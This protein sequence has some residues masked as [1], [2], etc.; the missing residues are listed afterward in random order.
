MNPLDL[1]AAMKRVGHRVEAVT[2]EPVNPLDA[3]LGKSRN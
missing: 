2:D 3:G 1:A